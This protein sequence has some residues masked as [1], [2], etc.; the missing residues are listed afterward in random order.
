MKNE[1]AKVDRRRREET[2][3]MGNVFWGPWEW[4][5]TNKIIMM[6][7]WK[8][9]RFFSANTY[10]DEWIQDDGAT[11]HISHDMSYSG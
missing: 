8:G 5:P 3:L 11:D 1:L 9:W 2:R 6:L 10:H 7:I 4:T